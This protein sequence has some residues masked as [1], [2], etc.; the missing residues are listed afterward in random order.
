[1]RSIDSLPAFSVAYVIASDGHDIFADMAL[2]SMLSVR[3]SNPGL[4]I[5]AMCD[6]KSAQA[7]K[8][9][10]HRLLQACDELVAVPTPEGEPT[11][12]HR[13]VKTQLASYLNGNAL[14]LDADTLVRRSLAD[15][16]PLISEFGAVANHN[17]TTL[18]EQIWSEDGQTLKKMGWS[19]NFEVYVNSGVFFFKP[20]PR[21]HEI[22]DNWHDLWLAGI[23]TNGRL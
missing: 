23:A 13:W 16:P 4:R 11:F 12:R 3:I 17:G 2:V 14:Y 21:V 9:T 19:E 5:V 10:Q 6:E 7:I 18:S 22:F 20:C 1:R 8:A 15:L